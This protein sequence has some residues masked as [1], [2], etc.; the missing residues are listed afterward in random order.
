MAG[1]EKLSRTSEYFYIGS[2]INFDCEGNS[3]IN[4]N[5]ILKNFTL[6]RYHKIHFL[7]FLS[8]KIR[9]VID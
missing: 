2:Q 9:D 5:R 6:L 7:E 4:V 1:F 8:R 3:F